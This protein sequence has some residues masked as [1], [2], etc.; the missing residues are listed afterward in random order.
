[1]VNA[2]EKVSNIHLEDIF[3]IL[4]VRLNPFLN[5]PFPVVCPSV[6]NTPAGKLIH[7]FHKNVIT[8]SDNDVMNHLLVIVTRFLNHSRFLARSFVDAHFPVSR[9]SPCL[10]RMRYVVPLRCCIL[11]LLNDV[12]DMLLNVVRV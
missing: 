5:V 8:G 11:K 2:L 6:R 7:S 3:A 9:R 10:F 12:L 1:M 4:S